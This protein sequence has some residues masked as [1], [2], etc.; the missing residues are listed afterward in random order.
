MQSHRLSWLILVALI[1]FS[2]RFFL[3]TQLF[4]THDLEYHA[5]RTANYYLALQQGQIPPRWSPNLN[6]SFGLPTFMFAYPLPYFAATA[7]FLLV[8]SIQLSVNLAL[9]SFWCIGSFGMFYYAKVRT[10]HNFYALLVALSYFAAPY[11]LLVFFER[12]AFGEASFFALLPL[13][14]L[15]IH[16]QNNIRSPWYLLGSYGILLAFLLTHPQSLVAAVPILVGWTLLG[17]KKIILLKYWRQKVFLL[18]SVCLSVQFFWIPLLLEAKQTYISEAISSTRLLH[19]FPVF[20]RLFWPTLPAVQV[21]AGPMLITDFTTTLGVSL[22]LL[23]AGGIFVVTSKK[24]T[25]TQFFWLAIILLSI[26][27]R[28]PAASFFGHTLVHSKLSN[29]LGDCCLLVCLPAPCSLLS[30]YLS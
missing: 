22:L 14:L 2:G 18:V 26:F 9:F 25:I 3:S 13:V 20:S 8:G 29:F 23:L 7:F 21:I 30:A 15:A 28:H 11:S 6:Y 16:W 27:F 12:G 5:A 1:L 4:D 24:R 17:Y 10:E 19:S